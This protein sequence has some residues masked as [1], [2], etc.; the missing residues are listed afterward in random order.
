MI[1]AVIILL[2]IAA[3]TLW[4]IAA[5]AASSK[6]AWVRC[7]ECG[8]MYI[9]DDDFPFQCPACAR[10]RERLTKHN[11]DLADRWG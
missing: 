3:M 10:T 11:Q 4:L 6:P 8:L 7:A 9:A 5:A 1:S 2:I